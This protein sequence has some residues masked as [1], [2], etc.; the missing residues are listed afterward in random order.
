MSA[1]AT[2]R[3]GSSRR[4]RHQRAAVGAGDRIGEPH[5]EACR[6]PRADSGTVAAFA[7]RVGKRDQ[8]VVVGVGRQWPG[9]ANQLPPARGGDAPGVQHTQVPRVR[10]GHGGQWAHYSCRVGIDEGE[11]RDRIVRAP[12]PAAAT[13]NIHSERLSCT[14]AR[15][16]ADT[17]TRRPPDSQPLRSFS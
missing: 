17:R 10:L 14:I 3:L 11:R 7:H 5:G 16:A 2:V 1:T 12:R 4:R 9:M 13:G 8:V 6:G 15:M